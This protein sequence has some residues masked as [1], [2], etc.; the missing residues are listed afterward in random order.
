M[1]KEISRRHF[2]RDGLVWSGGILAAT[3]VPGL[4][5]TRTAHAQ[6]PEL[7]EEN[8]AELARLVERFGPSRFVPVFEYHGDKYSMYQDQYNMNPE[9]F[10]EQMSWLRNRIVHAVTGPELT[11]FLRGDVELPS[12]SIILTTDS[13]ATSDRS[14]PRMIEVLNE[15]DMHFHSFIWTMDMEEGTSNWEIFR[16]ALDSGRFTLG[17]HT[18]TH[19]DFATLTAQEGIRELVYSKRKIED[20]LGISVNSISWPFESCPSWADQLSDYGFDYAFA[21][22]SRDMNSCGVVKNDAQVWT[23][24]RIFPPNV[25]GFSGRPGGWSMEDI[26]EAYTGVDF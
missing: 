14:M 2:I 25:N 18:E 3:Q 26:M 12:R 7:S 21:G 5:E 16:A 1:S 6:G 4:L 22:T 19:R 20:N 17:T 23:L 10:A 13:G 15:T 11:A 8:R 9:A 24:P